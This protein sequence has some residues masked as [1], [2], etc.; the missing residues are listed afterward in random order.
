LEIKYQ[1]NLSG[2]HSAR[3][4]DHSAPESFGAIVRLPR[5]ISGDKSGRS[6]K[7]SP[8][9]VAAFLLEAQQSHRVM[10]FQ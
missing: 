4:R 1:L 5:Q 7:R 9:C 3:D 6:H 8:A 2:S 10:L